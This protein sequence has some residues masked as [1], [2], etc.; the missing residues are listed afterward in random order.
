MKNILLGFGFLAVL[1]LVGCQAGSDNTDVVE[2]PV[3]VNVDAGSNGVQGAIDVKVVDEADL[4]VDSEAPSKIVSALV[5][6]KVLYYHGATCPHCHALKAFLPEVE[7]MYPGLMV[8][9]YEIWN[10]PANAAKARKHIAEL[11]YKLEGVPAIV[12]EGEVISG[13]S[14]QGLLALM[15]RHYGD[16]VE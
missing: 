1:G 12:V 13:F 5:I 16:P 2:D 3:V 9:E 7:K 4:E 6:P 11:G 8:E 15:K 14:E 10:N